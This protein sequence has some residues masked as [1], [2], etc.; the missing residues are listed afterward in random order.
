MRTARA[1]VSAV[2]LLL[3][4]AIWMLADVRLVT[5]LHLNDL[6]ARP[7]PDERG[8][9]GF[10]HVATGIGAGKRI[11]TSAPVLHFGDM[12]QRR[13]ASTAFQGTPVF[14]VANSLDFDTH[15]LGNRDGGSTAATRTP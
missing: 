6:H 4:L 13:S 7:L 9:G 8:L 15:S 5:I 12:V 10:A 1:L 14:E 2:L 11:A 3:S